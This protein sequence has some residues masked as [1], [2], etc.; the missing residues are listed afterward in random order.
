M[1]KNITLA[2]LCQR[3]IYIIK[4]SGVQSTPFSHPQASHIIWILHEMLKVTGCAKV[5]TAKKKLDK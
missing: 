4:G 3:E 2:G 5:Y 1:L